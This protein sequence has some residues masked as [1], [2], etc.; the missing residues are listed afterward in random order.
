VT[1]LFAGLSIGLGAGLTPGP[2]L[3]LVFTS[4][5]DRGFGA[6]LRVAVAPLIT[7]APIVSLAVAVAGTVPDAAARGLAVAGG[8]LVAALG[9]HTMWKA[10]AEPGTTMSAPGAHDVWRGALVNALSPHPWIFWMAAG[11][12]LL[13][14]AWRRNPAFGIAFVVGFY[15]MLVGS[16]AA[17][18]WVAARG[19]GR[20]R[21]FWRHGL[22]LLGGAALVAGG[23]VL[24][25]QAVRGRL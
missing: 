3:A 19:S 25:W 5:I 23:A 12:P 22:L 1:E 6:G 13:V 18:A 15:T 2:L 17:L 20:L 11:G 10:R 4:S 8:I 7:D 9:V 16:K 24:L 14:A 21:P